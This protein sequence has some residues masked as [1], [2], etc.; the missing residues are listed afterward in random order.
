MCEQKKPTAGLSTGQ[1]E[2]RK[3]T[4]SFIRSSWK[5]VVMALEAALMHTQTDDPSLHYQIP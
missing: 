3:C 5:A 2:L 1:Q 4:N